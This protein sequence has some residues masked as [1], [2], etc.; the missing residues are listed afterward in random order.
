M[1]IDG[2][3]IPKAHM[4]LNWLGGNNPQPIYFLDSRCGAVLSWRII[5]DKVAEQDPGQGICPVSATIDVS[6]TH[7]N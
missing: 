4:D 2:G 5:P 7:K 6:V 1:K 3:L